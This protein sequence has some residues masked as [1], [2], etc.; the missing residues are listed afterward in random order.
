[1]MIALVCLVSSVLLVGG[2]F[3]FGRAGASGEG[4]SAGES[5]PELNFKIE[6]AEAAVAEARRQ[7][8]AAAGEARKQIDAERSSFEMKVASAKLER[9]RYSSELEKALKQARP[10]SPDADVSSKKQLEDLTERTA[11]AEAQRDEFQA[12]FKDLEEKLRRSRPSIPSIEMERDIKQSRDEIDR[13][14]KELT[15]QDSRIAGLQATVEKSAAVLESV[16][17]ERD[18]ARERKEAADRIID[19]VR[20][21]STGLQQQ[22]KDAQAELAKLK[23]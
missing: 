3:L 23:G 9:D 19:G 20:A 7:A 16:T 11:R 12:K 5:S 6:Q 22:L 8:E 4:E 18:E 10:D 13:L 2:G 21:R 15:T 14:R 1:M 17:Q